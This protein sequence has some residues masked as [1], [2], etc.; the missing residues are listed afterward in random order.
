[1]AGTSPAMM[2]CERRYEQTLNRDAIKS[3][4]PFAPGKGGPS[5]I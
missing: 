5:A 1:M 2:T 3:I 4:R